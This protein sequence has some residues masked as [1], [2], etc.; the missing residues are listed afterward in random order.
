MQHQIDR[1]VETLEEAY[2]PESCREE[3]AEAIGTALDIL[4]GDD[5]DGGEGPEEVEPEFS[6]YVEELDRD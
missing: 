1:A 4:R 2:Q 5:E 3:M 6:A